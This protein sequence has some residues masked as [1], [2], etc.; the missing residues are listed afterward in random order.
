MSRR[1]PLSLTTIVTAILVAPIIATAANPPAPTSPGQPIQD[2]C[3]RN[4]SGVIFLKTPE[5][6]Y[7]NRDPRLRTASGL[8]R[9]SHLARDDAPGEHASHDYNANLVVAAS[10]RYLLGGDP[11]TKTGNF[12]PGDGEELG[13]LHFEWE[14]GV[15]PDYAWPTD[16]DHARLWGS[17]IW[18]CGHWMGGGGSVTG[19]RTEFH[20]LTAMAVD[21]RAPFEPRTTQSETDVFISSHG[22]GARAVE[23]CAHTLTP[24][25]ASEY[26]PDYRA[27]V[28]SNTSRNTAHDA[29]QPV[30]GR[31]SFFVP[32][33]PRPSGNARLTYRIVKRVGGNAGR[34]RVKVTRTGLA[35][36]VTLA[37]RATEARPIRYGKSFFAQWTGRQRSRPTP[38]KVTFGTLTIHHADPDLTDRDPSG[39]KWNLYIDLNG[40]RKLI[41][42]WVPGLASVTDGQK[43]AINRTVKI[44]VPA[45][46]S[47]NLLVSGRECDIPSNKVVF[48]EFAPIVA[49]CPAN[50][51]EPQIHLTNDDPGLILDIFRS[52]R[53]AIGSHSST[54]VATTNRFPGSRP[55]SFGDR[56]Q[57]AGDYTLSYTVRRG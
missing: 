7:V 27:C 13:R 41:N 1:I 6:V 11:A 52:G 50:T 29:P 31:Y 22:T 34:E 56:K 33:P 44:N 3:Q 38:L 35:V 37:G 21:R 53:A 10:D 17:W 26:G 47:L 28:Q 55:L 43:L 30:A 40:Y 16:G 46:R 42:R 15:V 45:G 54:S 49:P 12:T 20:P 23:Q 4:A 8:V 36:T 57:G 48:G 51:D 14:S 24:I 39:G 9:V 32:A 5:W 19:E 18:D 25:S 2:G